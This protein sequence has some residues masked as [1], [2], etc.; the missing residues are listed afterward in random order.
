MRPRLAISGRRD[1]HATFT[2]GPSAFPH[3]QTL[4]NESL[5]DGHH[6]DWRTPEEA[7]AAPTSRRESVLAP[8]EFTA[9]TRLT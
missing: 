8:S 1:A 3:H 5:W 7:V 9:A 4:S 6:S 2:A